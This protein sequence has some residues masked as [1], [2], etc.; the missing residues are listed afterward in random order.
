MGFQSLFLKTNK[1]NFNKITTYD[2]ELKPESNVAPVH[3]VPCLYA[4]PEAVDVYNLV[5]CFLYAEP[6][7]D[8][9]ELGFIL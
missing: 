7:A 8:P 6:E 2:F 5:P 1:I 3:L 4:E 9:N